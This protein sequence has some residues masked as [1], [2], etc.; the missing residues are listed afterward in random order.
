[1]DGGA[2]MFKVLVLH[3]PLSKDAVRHDDE[4]VE[5]LSEFTFLEKLYTLG[6][7]FEFDWVRER[8]YHAELIVHS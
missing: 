1:M 2:L 4:I 7:D 6:C 8:G 3:V 5:F